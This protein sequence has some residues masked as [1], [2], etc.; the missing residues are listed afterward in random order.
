MRGDLFNQ[1]NRVATRVWQSIESFLQGAGEMCS[2]RRTQGPRA[3]GG[4]A[5]PGSSSARSAAT[6]AAASPSAS[7]WA[8]RSCSASSAAASTM[9]ASSPAGRNCRTPSM[10]VRW[11]T[12]RSNAHKLASSNAASVKGVVE[13]IILTNAPRPRTGRWPSAWR[14]PATRRSV[15]ARAEDQLG[16]SFGRLIGLEAGPW[17]RRPRSAS[18]QDAA[19]HAHPGSLGTGAF[20]PA[21]ECPSHRARLLALFGLGNPN[22]HCRCAAHGPGGHDSA[23]PAAIPGFGPTSRRHRR[24]NAR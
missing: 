2:R 11:P 22:R 1:I 5:M 13:Q 9:P 18:C 19:V 12:N 15:F 24:P 23:R 8:C 21:E 20:T 7:P 16:L 17:P 4:S 14:S 10:P 6:A 3:G